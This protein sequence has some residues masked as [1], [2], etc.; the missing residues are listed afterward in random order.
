MCKCWEYSQG[1]AAYVTER[2]EVR[3]SERPTSRFLDMGNQ[4]MLSKCACA[5]EKD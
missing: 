3:R 5:W 4:Y 2:C 1:Q